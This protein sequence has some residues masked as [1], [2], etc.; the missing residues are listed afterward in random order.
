MRLPAQTQSWPDAFFHFSRNYLPSGTFPR[1]ETDTL[2]DDQL[3]DILRCP[4]DRSELTLASPALVERVNQQI[5]AGKLSS[6]GGQAVS[7][8]IDGGLLRAAGDLLYPILGGIPVMLYDEA[9]E[10]SRIQ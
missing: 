4:Q 1:R 5:A 9:I 2:I 3:L 8:P 7:K 6:L 10:V